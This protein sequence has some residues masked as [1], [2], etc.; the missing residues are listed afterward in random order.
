MGMLY[1]FLTRFTPQILEVYSSIWNSVYSEKFGNGFL[2]SDFSLGLLPVV[3]N[4]EKF[5]K[6]TQ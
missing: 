3:S 4:D 2:S 5:V 1:R 6:K